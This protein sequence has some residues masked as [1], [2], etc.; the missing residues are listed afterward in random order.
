[1]VHETMRQNIE[2]L[3]GPLPFEPRWWQWQARKRDRFIQTV[4]SDNGLPP[5]TAEGRLRYYS[6]D[7][8][9]LEDAGGAW[10]RKWCAALGLSYLDAFTSE[11]HP[12]AAIDAALKG[13]SHE[14][15]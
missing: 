10:S 13:A 2:L 11:I 15:G 6:A 5:L 1:M 7:P 8:Q 3:E 4:L 9:G 14:Q 12:R